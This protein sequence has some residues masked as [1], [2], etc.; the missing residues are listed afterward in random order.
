MFSVIVLVGGGTWLLNTRIDDPESNV[1]R[2]FVLRAGS[3][4]FESAPTGLAP[5][6]FVT[7]SVDSRGMAVETTT[8]TGAP[9]TLRWNGSA[10]VPGD[11]AQVDAT[12]VSD[13]PL[14]T[15]LPD[16]GRIIRVGDLQYERPDR[17]RA[18]ISIPGGA[19]AYFAV[20]AGPHR[21]LLVVGRQGTT[22]YLFDTS[23]LA[24]T[25]GPEL[26]PNARTFGGAD[27]EGT[28]FVF[29]ET[30]RQLEHWDRAVRPGGLFLLGLLG[31]LVIVVVFVRLG[32]PSDVG[33]GLLVGFL[34]ALVAMVG[35][36]GLFYWGMSNMQFL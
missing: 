22:T 30:S 2:M 25:P 8:S 23:S 24:L 12:P 13:D 6:P 10:L 4:T 14:W 11:P 20:P 1:D 31:L 29:P 5:G 16:G 32:R 28:A 9:V 35:L 26:P 34:A 15:M 27:Q 36:F 19:V 33:A 3:S 21:V 7:L 18:P 17:T